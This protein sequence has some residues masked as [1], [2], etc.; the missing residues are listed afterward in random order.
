ML[1]VT[2]LRAN[3]AIIGSALLLGSGPVTATVQQLD[4]KGANAAVPVEYAQELLSLAPGQSLKSI[5][6]KSPASP[7]RKEDTTQT[8]PDAAGDRAAHKLVVSVGRRIERSA[9]TNRATYLRLS[10]GGGMSFAKSATML[11]ENW[12]VGIDPKGASSCTYDSDTSNDSDDDRTVDYPPAYRESGLPLTMVHSSGGAVGDTYVVFRIDFRD[13]GLDFDG[14]GANNLNDIPLNVSMYDA[15]ETDPPT[16]PNTADTSDSE[17]CD[18][19][20]STTQL[21]VNVQDMFMIPSGKGKYTATITMHTDPDHAQRG[22]IASSALYGSATIVQAVDARY[23]AVKANRRPAVAHVG[24]SPKPFLW[25]RDTSAAN[26]LSSSAVLGMARATVGREDLLNPKTGIAAT[27]DELILPKSLT[28]AVEGNLSIGAFNLGTDGTGDPKCVGQGTEDKATVGNLDKADTNNNTDSKAVLGSLDAGTYH[29]CVQVDTAGPGSNATPIP[30]GTYH[31][32]ITEGTGAQAKTIAS[33][34]IG[35]IIRNGATVKLTY[36]TVSTKYNQRL[37]IVN[38]GVNEALYD[39]DSFHT[40]EGTTTTRLSGA[41]GSVPANGQVVV[42]VRDIVRLDSAS[43][44]MTYHASATLRMNADL[45]DVQVA[46]T[47]VN[48]ED[49]STDTVVYAADDGAVVH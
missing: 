34:V 25:F 19:A 41:S 12:R 7:I 9:N 17:A 16:D 39:I 5:V 47:Q 30:A 46:T 38:E 27:K 6:I 29:L 21:W 10:L 14:T 24:T 8:P 11:S 13:E 48:L 36:L 20:A 43:G 32:A 2:S 23:V 18:I 28:V 49:G 22:T 37:I 33:G 26:E 4:G 3:L 35:R 45:D 44:R 42:P 1:N 31:A 15:D 40:G